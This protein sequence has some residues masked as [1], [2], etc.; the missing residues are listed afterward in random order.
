[1]ITSLRLLN[2]K[3]FADETLRIGPFTVIVGANASGKSNIRDAFRFL[4]GIGR[5]YTL[6]EI[7]GGKY[8]T[9]WEP[10]RGGA[11]GMARFGT[12]QP[13]EEARN[14]ALELQLRLAPGGFAFTVDRQPRQAD[15][16][17]EAYAVPLSGGGLEVAS[18]RLE[19]DSRKVYSEDVFHDT[20]TPTAPTQPA[21]HQILRCNINQ[22]VYE[23]TRMVI[24]VLR[25]TRFLDF[26][27]GVMRK[28]ASPGQPLGDHGENLPLA[29]KRICADAGRKATLIDWIRELT[30]MDVH[31]FDFLEDPSKHLHLVI[32]DHDGRIVPA[33][34][35]SDGTLR[36]L[37][38]LASLLDEDARGLYVFEE[39]ENGLHPSRLHLLLDLIERQTATG[40]VQ[41]IATTHSPELLS[42]VTDETFENVAVTCRL[43]DACDAI[44]R[45]VAELPGAGK[46][47]TSQGLG[48]LLAG[49]WMEDALAFTEGGDGGTR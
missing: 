49:S 2:F 7:V 44:I 32:E 5:G 11:G 4:H 39:I 23:E 34:S 14:F 46:L 6:A 30:P 37:A 47:R 27:P 28:P 19:V 41:V 43:E 33:E 17:I 42:M 38:M 35:A 36:F 40:R 45:R 1:M 8:G 3:N 18:E 20:D 15:Y 24:E 31:D 9:D 13:Y 16:R 22:Q 12:R 21:L 48:R 26:T 10:I 29:L 25:G